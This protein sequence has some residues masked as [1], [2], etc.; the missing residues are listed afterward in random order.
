MIRYQ[1]SQSDRCARPNH[2]KDLQIVGMLIPHCPR[3]G[4][5]Q[6]AKPQGRVS[7]VVPPG[8]GGGGIFPIM[9]YTGGRDFTSLGI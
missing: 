9:A 6:S 1:T 3:W 8:G 5:G 4:L 2:A 7:T